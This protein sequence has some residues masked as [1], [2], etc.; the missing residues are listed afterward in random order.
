MLCNMTCFLLVI[1][2]RVCFVA[3][4]CLEEGKKLARKLAVSVL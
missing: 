3:P 1:D 4:F 2:E